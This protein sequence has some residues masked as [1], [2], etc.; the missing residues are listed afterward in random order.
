[1]WSW[2]GSEEGS[3]SFILAEANFNRRCPPKLL[4]VVPIGKFF[5]L[6]FFGFLFFFLLLIF[7]SIT[8]SNKNKEHN[9]HIDIAMDDYFLNLFIVLLTFS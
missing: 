2:G 3:V 5:I 4:L 8:E 7:F 9:K 6:L 1:L